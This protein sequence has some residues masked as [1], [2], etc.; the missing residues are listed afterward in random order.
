MFVN[1]WEPNNLYT[2]KKTAYFIYLFTYLLI[3]YFWVRES[4]S[5]GEGQREREKESEADSEVGLDSTTRG[6]WPESDTQ[7]TEPPRQPD[8]VLN[9]N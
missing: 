3:Y 6:P 9:I 2:L 4:T 5:E 7:L 1:V 8:A